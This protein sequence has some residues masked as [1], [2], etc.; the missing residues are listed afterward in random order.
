M[1]F[2][3]HRHR[4]HH[5]GFT[6]I[7]LLVV[8]SII[9]IL[10]AVILVGG[11]GAINAA[12]RAKAANTAT[13]IQTA[14]MSY[15]TEYG[16]YPVVS[17]ATPADTALTDTGGETD[18]MNAL[19]GNVNAS[20]GTTT[21]G[22][23]P[24]TRGIVFLTPKKNEVDTNGVLISP[25]TSGTASLVFS[26]AMDSD[27]SGQLGDSGGILAKM[28]DFSTWTTG[29]TPP[30]LS[31]AITQ[32]VAIWMCCDPSHLTSPTTSTSPGY[33]VHTY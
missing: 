22:A 2:I 32:Q 13:Q 9:A 20:T 31:H 26:I 15:Y 7:E 3:P 16:V 25:F 8:M 30:V 29:Q 27:Y 5:K 14:I 18:M 19:C 12:K 28:P 33:W 6:L 10:A 1:K 4:C 21:T 17:S 11:S 24:N 23:V